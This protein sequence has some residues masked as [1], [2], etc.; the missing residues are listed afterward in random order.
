MIKRF[1]KWIKSLFCK[2]KKAKYVLVW[3]DNH[4]LDEKWEDCLPGKSSWNKYM[5]GMSLFHTAEGGFTRFRCDKFLETYQTSG[6][7]TADYLPDG[8]IIVVARFKGGHATWPAIWMSSENKSHDLTTYKDYFEIDLSEYYETRDNTETTYHFPKSMRK[9][10]KSH[11][12][13]TAINPEEWNT[14]ECEWNDSELSVS[15]NGKKIWSLKNDGDPDVFPIEEYQRRF[16][17]IISMQYGNKWLSEPVPDELPLW[18]DVK[19]VK[20]YK[21]I[22]K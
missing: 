3:K 18:M 10:C 5:T 12:V 14:F 8:K 16:C 9:E 4:F 7:R 21:L 13:K 1:F 17:L 15:I 19:N 2:S 20:Y 22:K 11:N 6:V